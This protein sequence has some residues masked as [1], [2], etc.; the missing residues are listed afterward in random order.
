[1]I[2]TWQGGLP[3]TPQLATSVSNAGGSRPMRYKS[4]K[5]DNPDPSHWYDTSFNTAD[6][7]WG[8][9]QT[10][11]FGNGGRNVL[12]GPGR[13]NWDFSLFKDF[14]PSERYHLQFRFEVFN[15][16]NTPQFDLPNSSI[17]GASAGIISAVIGTPR[18]LQYGLRFSF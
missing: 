17:G 4:G 16:L 12:R 1:V 15:M 9:P 10:F 14:L 7:A 11:T 18:Q 13:I 6:A 3:F 5:I 2:W 8:I